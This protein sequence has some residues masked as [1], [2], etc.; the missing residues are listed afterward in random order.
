MNANIYFSVPG[1]A[2]VRWDVAGRMVVVEWEGWANSAEFN[3]LLDAEIKALETHRGGLL[4]ADCTLQRVLNTAE[5]ERANREW[6]PRAVAAGL[7]KFA[8]VLPVS[9]L[10]AAHIR[11]RTSEALPSAYEVAYF[12]DVERATS[13]LHT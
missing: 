5:Q 6:I 4:L 7:K 2:S 1:V 10:A 9:Q 13:W 12:D 8:I 3:A 11:E